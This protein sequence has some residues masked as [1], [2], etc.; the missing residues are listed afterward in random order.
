[1]PLGARADRQLRPGPPRGCDRRALDRQ[2]VG[3]GTGAA[4][5]PGRS[6]RAGVPARRRRRAR[7]ERRAARDR[8]AADD[9]GHARMGER[10]RAP[11]PYPRND[12]THP[13]ALQR[14]PA[15]GLTT[16]GRFDAALARWFHRVRLPLWATEIGYRTSP[17]IPGA[18]PYPLQALFA[19]Q[20]L[21]LAR[22]QAG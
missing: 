3:R 4:A 8:G 6:V 11:D 1:V 13:G 15:V 21:A 19:A 14:W 2:L 22:A 9:L 5:A 12:L 16:L 7:A 17:E 10:R 18:A 20:T